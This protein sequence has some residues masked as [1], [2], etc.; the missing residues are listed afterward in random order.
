MIKNILSFRIV[1]LTALMVATFSLSSG[2]AL[3]ILHTNDTHSNIEPAS[4]GRNAGLGG[5]QRRAN[6]I[7]KMRSQFPDLL[8]L[9]A[10]DYNQGTPY[11]T[12][13]KGAAEIELYNAMGY[14]AVCLGNH[15]F[16]NGQ[17]QLADR[18]KKAN[19]P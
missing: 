7:E 11:F 2:Q 12:L 13:F 15:E 16:D 8:L 1:L 4:S 6:Y 3:V 17:K 19:Y 14:D 18:L 10:G 5:F 9:D